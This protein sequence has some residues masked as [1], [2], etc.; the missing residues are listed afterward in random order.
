MDS[1][2]LVPAALAVLSA[3]LLASF[4]AELGFLTQQEDGRPQ[5]PDFTN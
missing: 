5:F 2:T 4:S 3:L 1:G